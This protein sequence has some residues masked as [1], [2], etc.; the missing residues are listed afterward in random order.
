MHSLKLIRWVVGY[1]FFVSGVLKIVTPGAAGVFS[2]YGIPYPGETVLVVGIIELL[3][4]L[5]LFLDYEVRKVTIPL[6]VIMV[7]A[8]LI[9]KV[10]LLSTEGLPTFL[11]QS[12]LD[13]VMV[14]L[15]SIL[16]KR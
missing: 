10:P 16:Y 9:T 6:L 15:L 4:G 7:G 12:K 2:G 13:I 1:V 3:C 11:F 8:L 14:V 5:F